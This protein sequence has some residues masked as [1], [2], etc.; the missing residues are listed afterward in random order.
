SAKRTRGPARA[1]AAGRG[2]AGWRGGAGLALLWGRLSFAPPWTVVKMLRGLAGSP[3]ESV[4]GCALAW[5]RWLVEL[6]G[7][8][9]QLTRRRAALPPARAAGR[10]RLGGGARGSGVGRSSRPG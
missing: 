1:P 4:G 2:R 10:S 9:Q 3:S 7:A 5:R 8:D 6:A